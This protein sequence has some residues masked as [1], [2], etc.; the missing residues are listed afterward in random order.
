MFLLKPCKA[1][2]QAVL[3]AL[4]VTA[5]DY[6][7]ELH[8]LIVESGHYHLQLTDHFGYLPDFLR[9]FHALVAKLMN[10]HWKRSE[11]LWSTEQTN[12][13]ELVTAADAFDKLIYTVTNPAKDHLVERAHHWPGINSIKAAYCDREVKVRRP[14]WYFDPNG[15]MPKEVSFRFTRPPGFEHLTQE[16]WKAKVATAVTKVEQDAAEERKA[17]GTS[18]V[19]RKA[20]RRQSAF[21]RPSSPE[22]RGGIIPRVAC[23]DPE[24]R[25]DI[26]RRN[27][28]WLA[29]YKEALAAYRAGD[30]AVLFPPGTW[31]LNKDTHVRTAPG[32]EPLAIPYALQLAAA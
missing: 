18:I 25:K 8:A 12:V 24:R 26:L 31:Q 17:K 6:G 10:A 20:I 7:I 28:L 15:D 5:Q 2:E 29:Q 11:N 3:Y 9:D 21:A 14:H 1:T 19:G 32:T 23:K 27:K 16:E 4:G 13:V 22:P 30:K